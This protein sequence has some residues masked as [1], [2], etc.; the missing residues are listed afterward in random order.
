MR[1]LIAGGTGFVGSSLARS[2]TS[3]GHSVSILTRRAA[4]HPGEIQWD[5]RSASAWA[6]N[7][8][9]FGAVI[10]TTGFGLEHWPWT[11]ARKR[12]FL[13]SRVVPCAAIASAILASA[14]RPAVLVQIS[15]INYYGLRGAGIADETTPPGTDFLAR[16]AVQWEAATEPVEQVGVRRVVARSAVVLDA[17]RGL[18][19]LMALP[20]RLMA[21]GRLGNGQQAVPW[22]HVQ[23]ELEALRFLM[24]N[25]TAAGAFN[26][27]APQQTSNA[28]FMRSVARALRRPY[29]LPTP[30]FL[31]RAVLGEMSDLILEGR[32]SAPRRLE[33]LG[34]RFSYPTLDAALD[35]LF[36]RSQM[37][38]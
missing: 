24:E 28:E 18:F 16:L 20:V 13:D 29:W 4:R 26:L 19:P 33:Q 11:A 21:G 7:I 23:D 8:A 2:L 14:R 15:G 30:G 5:G 27:I 35:N 10:N 31:L 22:I 32:Y 3:A 25:E 36:R 1:V 17:R 38:T 6:G 37:T 12:R 34:F 9:D